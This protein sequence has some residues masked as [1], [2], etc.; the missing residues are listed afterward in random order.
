MTLLLQRMLPPVLCW[1]QFIFSLFQ[2]WALL[3]SANFGAPA[4]LQ[5]LLHLTAF[6]HMA[7]ENLSLWVYSNSVSH[8][9]THKCIRPEIELQES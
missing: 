5:G 8:L 2:S 1:S 7:L 4:P 9:P 6:L 3:L